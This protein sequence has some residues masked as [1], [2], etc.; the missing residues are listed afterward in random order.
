VIGL[1]AVEFTIGYTGFLQFATS[2]YQTP[3][4]LA[5]GFMIWGLWSIPDTHPVARCLSFK[6]FVYFGGMSYTLYL[7]H[8]IALELFHKAQ[9]ALPILQA[10]N[11][12]AGGFV[13]SLLMG[14]LIW[15]LWENPIYSL[16]RFLPY[17]A[18]P[19]LGRP[20]PVNA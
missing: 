13:M 5:L 16:R 8:L 1:I 15:H 12:V 11:P 6:P 20:E 19:K 14:M 3:I 18:M 9:A 7:I 4:A 17:G 2:H 10:V